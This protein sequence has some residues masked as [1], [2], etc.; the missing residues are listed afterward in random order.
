[1]PAW[2]LISI[3]VCVVACG[4]GG[5]K[6]P[7][8]HEPP[9]PRS[10]PYTFK[11]YVNNGTTQTLVQV[12]P[13]EVAAA[14]N[15]KA[16]Q[17]GGPVTKAFGLRTLDAKLLDNP[18]TTGSGAEPIILTGP[19]ELIK[20]A[21]TECGMVGDPSNTISSQGSQFLGDIRFQDIIRQENNQQRITGYVPVDL[22]SLTPDNSAISYSMFPKAPATCDE[23]LEDEETLVCVADK[24]AQ[25]AD[26]VGPLTW[27]AVR[28]LPGAS[29]PQDTLEWII[30]PPAEQEKFIVRDLA[31][32][33][34][35]Q[36][37]MFDAD[38]Y[39]TLV[40]N[41]PS[42]A[43]DMT[44]S[45]AYG[46]FGFDDPSVPAG[47]T[48]YPPFD[49]T[50]SP[51]ATV[52][53][54]RWAFETG[55]LRGAGQL[56]HDLINESVYSDLAGAAA[57]AASAADP[58]AGQTR[59]FGSDG[60]SPYNSLAHVARTLMGRWDMD[61]QN[62]DP[63]CHGVAELDLL[64]Q[65]AG[66][67]LRARAEDLGAL[68]SSQA[69]AESLM[70]ESGLVITDG[71]TGDLAGPLLAQLSAINGAR[72]G[73]DAGT[74]SGSPAGQALTT[75]VGGLSAS[76]LARAAQHNRVTFSTITDTAT[77]D[78]T[79]IVT[80]AS[81]S[82]MI[83]GIPASGPIS[84]LAI[85]VAGGLPRAMAT[86]A[87]ARSGPMM[88]ASQCL[89][90]GTDPADTMFMFDDAQA[91]PDP[92]VVM[93]CQGP[94]PFDCSFA[95]LPPLFSR[96]DVFA[97]GNT[98]RSRLVKLREVADGSAPTSSTTSPDAQARAAAVSELGAWAGSGR[99]ILSTDL[100]YQSVDLTADGQPT[101]LPTNV[102]LD[103]VGIDLNDF[104]VQS[105]SDLQQAVSLVYG[106]AGGLSGPALAECAAHIRQCDPSANAAVWTA[107]AVDT[108]RL[109]STDPASLRSLFGIT[110]TNAR[111][112]FDVA[113]APASLVAKFGE[114]GGGTDHSGFA[115]EFYIVLAQ[116]PAK[117]PGIG[118]VLGALA[119]PA[120]SPG[121]PGTVYGQ[122]SLN[123]SPMR[124]QLLNSAFGLGRWVGAA[125]PKAGEQSLAL[126][127]S[128]C[129][130][131][132]PRDLFVPLANDL[133]SGTDNFE[134][135]WL[136]YLSLAQAAATNADTLAQ[137]LISIGFNK[138]TVAEGAAEQSSNISGSPTDVSALRVNPDGTLDPGGANAALSSLL[139]T[140][141]IDV[142]LFTSDPTNGKASASD[143]ANFIQC[144]T[145][146]PSTA[147]L[148][149]KLAAQP[150]VQF[151]DLTKDISTGPNSQWPTDPTILTYT[152]LGLS[153]P[154][155]ADTG[156]S[157]GDACAGVVSAA[158][159]L[160]GVTRTPPPTNCTSN[161][162][163]AEA[164]D[165]AASFQGGALG[166]GLSS[167]NPDPSAINLALNAAVMHV[168]D[169]T[170]W[171]V[172]YNGAR[173]MD[174]QSSTLWP[175]CLHPGTVMGMNGMLFSGGVQC[176]WTN[177]LVV[178]LN[179][180]L[181][182][183]SGPGGTEGDLRQ[184]IGSC[185][186]GDATAEINSLRWR[187]Q[188]ALW[189]AGMM[190]GGVHED[191]FETPIPAANLASPSFSAP[192][193]MFFDNGNFGNQMG[194]PTLLGTILGGDN[195][196]L[197]Q[198]GAAFLPFT[199]PW[200][201]WGP[202]AHNL[203]GWLQAVYAPSLGF[204]APFDT[205]DNP[206]S[207]RQYVHMFGTNLE[208]TADFT[209]NAQFFVD[210]GAGG[211]QNQI[212][213]SQWL[214]IL[215]HI[216][217]LQ[218]PNPDIESTPVPHGHGDV[219]NQYNDFGDGWIQGLVAVIKTSYAQSS[220]LW[221]GARWEDDAMIVQPAQY[222]YTPG[223]SPQT[224]TWGFGGDRAAAYNQPQL[225]GTTTGNDSQGFVTMSGPFSASVGAGTQDFMISKFTVQARVPFAVNSQIPQNMCDAGW[226]LTQAIALSC[227][228]D[229][230][231]Q[232]TVNAGVI[233]E[234]PQLN[235]TAD[236]DSLS[237][238]LTATLN[239]ATKALQ[240]DYLQNIPATVA[241]N[242]YLA[243]HNQ[244]ASGTLTGIGGT[245]GKDITAAANAIISVYQDWNS[246]LLDA[247]LVSGGIAKTRSAIDLAQ[248]NFNEQSIN[249]LIRTL[250][251]V[252]A[253]AEDVAQVA[254]SWQT[255]GSTTLPAGVALG[256]DVAIA[257]LIPNSMDVNLQEE[258]DKIA[259]T[260]LD[261]QDT[262][263]KSATDIQ[264]QLA[265][266]QQNVNN[267]SSS[268]S[269]I[270]SDRAMATYYA[271]KATGSDVWN[272]GTSQQPAECSSHV[273]TVLNRRYAGT[274]IRYQNALTQAKALGY[275][276]RR[277]IEQRIGISLN[278]LT[279]PIGPLPAPSTWADDVC[280]VVGVNYKEL[281][282]LTSAQAAF[283]DGGENAIAPI[284]SQI[285]TNFADAFVG[286]YVQKLTD[287][288]SY[289]NAVYPE[290][291]GND[292]AVLSLRETLLG[293]QPICRDASPN[294]LRDS[295]RLY[296]GAQSPGIQPF[297]WH[298]SSCAPTDATCLSVR[299][300]SSVNMPPG[301]A[302]GGVSWLSDAPNPAL[303]DAGAVPLGA[304][305]LL[306]WPDCP[307]MLPYFFAGTS[308]QA[309]FQTSTIAGPSG[310]SCSSDI[311]SGALFAAAESSGGAYFT[312]PGE[313]AGGTYTFE[314]DMQWVS[315]QDAW[316][317]SN[318]NGDGNSNGLWFPVQFP[319]DNAWRH[320]SYT[321]ALGPN[322][323]RSF[324]FVYQS[325][326]GPEEIRLDNA[327]LRFAAPDAPVGRLIISGG[328][329]ASVPDAGAEA[330]TSA[331]PP[332]PAVV[333]L[334]TLGA[335]GPYLLSWWDQARDA[336]GT[337]STVAVPYQVVVYDSA[338]TALAGFSGTPAPSDPTG[339]TWSA[340]NVLHINAPS[341]GVYYVALSASVPS[342]A[343]GSVAIA[344]LQ[345]EMQSSSMTPSPYVDTDGSGQTLD[346]QCG[347]TSAGLRA[348]FQ[349]NCDPDGTCHYDLT[350][351]ITIDTATLTSNGRSLKGKLANGNFNFRD[352]NVGLNVA[353]TGVIDCT[354]TG[355][356]D[357][358]GSGFLQYTLTHDASD[359]GVLGYDGQSRHFNFGIA[360]LDHAKALAA[361]RYLTTPLGSED[362]QLI[363]QV[364]AIQLA[365][366]PIDGVYTLRIYD[367]P[368]LHFDR[369][370]D[371]QLILNYH[372]WSRVAVLNGAH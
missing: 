258:K 178:G 198:S 114:V 16:R 311:V 329:N 47:P 155:G 321:A 187:V 195:N 297:G 4:P 20:A 210:V 69:L 309:H 315:G 362:Q 145:V 298:V 358:S 33:V 331:G 120:I 173:I 71:F 264:N 135:S 251:Q 74:Y 352:L 72:L 73:I 95:V 112:T 189:V 213:P 271:G 12:V 104:G 102:F 334:V 77:S 230:D 263:S 162:V 55:V 238:W 239:Q 160:K 31:M 265:T 254:S 176:D 113:S 32:E 53:R 76:D 123:L 360:A 14:A 365:G 312:T 137:E 42:L 105:V 67:G 108:G 5:T 240:G 84:L 124:V 151:I 152:A 40:P 115:K 325:V 368:A 21:A 208:G 274:E 313:V 197:V 291:N 219:V 180:S 323:P 57:G 7:A 356:K 281:T 372:Y 91:A 256:A 322:G 94:G 170:S 129:I 205:G 290:A 140:K 25:L 279:A 359:V 34:L 130:D 168:N 10:S 109:G 252:K 269:S 247:K 277:A 345:L 361:E 327:T 17:A 275:M 242:A 328:P 196:L 118:A 348:A 85:A 141:T 278:D 154:V 131:G 44:C 228:L 149:K 261:L 332:T 351:P 226:Q 186:G 200:F 293:G 289:Y 326:S 272:C 199:S 244:G 133:T 106:D 283:A 142:V 97:V 191:M 148:C 193:S 266:A 336:S 93:S 357:C 107:A 58:V 29:N 340:R 79:T 204:S 366:R 257:Q 209:P 134:N 287:F 220:A 241:L 13:R 343:P 126:T 92:S 96:Q 156:S 294:L 30:P 284:D 78:L 28:F 246:I 250:Q 267:I 46:A 83:P 353:G 127:P 63:M 27:H 299:A 128:F 157:K 136:H 317:F 80:G 305:D 182:W 177:P 3:I 121:F 231:S 192:S 22:W 188:G 222:K 6:S 119:L 81:A 116:D 237:N 227:L 211:V 103:L 296:L 163:I 371:I 167:W 52:A 38:W 330:G 229:R 70:E 143:L 132:V 144:N 335:P 203:P 292:T 233:Q 262:V 194:F 23:V 147:T 310:G 190:A 56:L 164:F 19:E 1:M 185:D 181:R 347:L 45:V 110:G 355:S 202:H 319:G 169:D 370:D 316:S 276:A 364:Q 232:N 159:G 153:P 15:A 304:P 122:A 87:V 344:D 9:A 2:L 146:P 245:A 117:A 161:C 288:V 303:G 139:N 285:A 89:E 24:L 183:C 98:I 223:L 363:G 346:Y 255:F 350:T 165:S 333:Q 249:N 318:Q 150:T 166:D 218:C 201:D 101:A 174:S 338:W 306:A 349:R 300:A 175:G 295:S 217:G 214:A 215:N 235:T 35:A 48:P 341:A 36:I 260:L 62:P 125:P 243:K 158:A 171:Y 268:A 88:V 270:A 236:L 37:P 86:D 314:F 68:T 225:I 273:N 11:F 111:L 99:A 61:T 337:P 64:P 66:P 339:S 367:T 172:A 369:V 259:A 354:A 54:E 253:I 308:P 324:M 90:Q 207:G 206:A 41:G 26:T 216:N 212:G 280:H 286:D 51:F 184:P 248:Q 234:P 65:L 18:P 82:G 302:T 60:K 100:G 320:Y 307:P 221:T 138:D 179:D 301:V 43:F 282:S 8:A 39:V 49:P 50:T 342:G 75:L 59:L 224:S